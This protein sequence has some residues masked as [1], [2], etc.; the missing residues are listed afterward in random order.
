MPPPG[1][2]RFAQTP[3]SRML[4]RPAM[5]EPVTTDAAERRDRILGLMIMASAFGAALGLSFWSHRVA[6]SPNKGDDRPAE[7]HALPGWPHAAEPMAV[8]RLARAMARPRGLGSLVVD[9][10]KSDGTVDLAKAGTAR[11]VFFRVTETRPAGKAPSCDR[12]VVRLGASGLVRGNVAT[13]QSCPEPRAVPL[14]E[15]GCGP[16]EL[17]EAALRKGASPKALARAEFYRAVSGPAWKF[18]LGRGNLS[19]VM[20]G[21]CARE[22]TSSEAQRPAP[23]R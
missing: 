3:A 2:T 12:L 1:G 22:L 21:R 18:R 4:Y 23:R 19:L 17:W 16:R 20:D 9:G 15:P 6:K 14:P 5:T 10:V 11:Y 8:L 7:T 13:R